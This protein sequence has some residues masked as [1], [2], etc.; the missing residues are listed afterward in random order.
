MPPTRYSASAA[1]AKGPWPVVGQISDFLAANPRGHLIVVTGYVSPSG[2]DW[3]A[4]KAA[5]R[6]VSLVVGDLDRSNLRGGSASSRSSAARFLQRSDV[7]AFAWKHAAPG[8]GPDIIC[9]AKLWAVVGGKDLSAALVGSANLT[10]TGMNLHFEIMV[11]A[12]DAYLGHLS[13]QMS[14]LLQNSE[15]AKEKI[16]KG[17]R[18]APRGKPPPRR[19]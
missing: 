5:S 17:M 2:L 9:H 18:G 15:N 10:Y 11:P 14:W 4:R 6:Q 19:R 16:L 12:A 1:R 7:R 3:L 8:R 13:N